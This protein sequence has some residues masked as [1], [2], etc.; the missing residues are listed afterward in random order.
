MN[1]LLTLFF[2][3]ILV[4]IVLA[5]FMRFGVPAYRVERSNVIKLL[6]M[7]Q[8]REATDSDWEVFISVPIRHDDELEQVRQQCEVIAERELMPG[9][10][11]QF[12]EQGLRELAV[13]LENLKQ[14]PIT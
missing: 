3:L 10:H 14:Q 13:V 7:V 5:V 11:C 2:T 9:G 4:V 1:F 6:E 12:S 8:A